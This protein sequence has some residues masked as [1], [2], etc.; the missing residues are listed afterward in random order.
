MDSIDIYLKG[1]IWIGIEINE[2]ENC[3]VDVSVISMDELF[4]LSLVLHNSIAVFQL[5]PE[6]IGHVTKHK[7]YKYK[8]FYIY[9]ELFSI[10]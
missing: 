8:K 9:G 5:N 7:W 6:F 10:H 4:N 3:K 2:K 1:G